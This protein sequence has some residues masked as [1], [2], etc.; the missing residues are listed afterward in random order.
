MGML[1]KGL[2][3]AFIAYRF[4]LLLGMQGYVHELFTGPTWSLLW[5]PIVSPM[6][7]N[8]SIAASFAAFGPD[9]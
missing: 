9:R 1:V 6:I 5:P 3:D 8:V 4:L 2:S 7:F